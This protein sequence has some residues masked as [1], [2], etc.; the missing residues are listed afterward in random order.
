MLALIARPNLIAIF[1]TSLFN[2]G[3]TPG[4]PRSILQACVL[5]G[6][7]KRVLAPEKILDFVANWT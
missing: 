2:T 4:I 5:G 7:P 3:S 6:D 1:K